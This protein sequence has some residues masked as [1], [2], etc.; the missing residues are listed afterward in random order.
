MGILIA[1]VIGS[2][3]QYNNYKEY[4]FYNNARMLAADQLNQ[5]KSC[6]KDDF[7]QVS[8]YK[9]GNYPVVICD[10]NGVVLYSEKKGYEAEDKVN[11]NEFIQI[12]HSLFLN[13]NDFVKTSFAIET[14]DKTVGFAAFYI[15]RKLA[16]GMEEQQVIL[17]IFMPVIIAGFFVVLLIVFNRRY[18]KYRVIRPV[19]EMIESS[20]AIIDGDY[21]VPVVKA[22]SS[23]L[24]SND[25]DR[26]S[27]NFE[28]M[29]DELKE[30]R[31][32]EEELKRSQKELISCISHDLK[33]P[34]STIKAYS[35]GLRDGMAKDSSKVEKYAEIILSKTEVLTKMIN[36]LLEHY[37]AELNQLSIVKKEQYFNDF[38]EKL[39]KEL[40]GVVFY[41]HMEYFFENT[42]PNLLV[43]F[44]ENRI[45]QVI[46]NLI[47]NSIKYGKREVGKI[48]MQVSYVEE[49]EQI[50]I[51]VWDNGP[52][53]GAS[54]IPFVFDKF[55]RGEKSRNMSIPGSGLGLSI[56]KYI[57]EAHNG[58]IQCE[59][60]K[61]QG[62]N[63]IISL[64]V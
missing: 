37:N 17:K 46:A 1:G 53:I 10:I 36:D 33:T 51:K 6:F 11:I 28:L 24:M 15:P 48:G 49:K 52:G 2:I 3:K 62:T 22:G 58:E 47:D 63:F 29:R 23:N 50:I 25:I 18:M 19:E 38:I 12:D 16:V 20:K 4:A 34:I 61:N 30:K 27:Y 42:A 59:S 40:K 35:E 45:T 41:N 31:R 9:K 57:I 14:S 21:N 44:D 32:R 55:Y 39:S 54:D 13:D 26:L 64:P 43:N 60:R 56:C 8:L 5:I 7:F